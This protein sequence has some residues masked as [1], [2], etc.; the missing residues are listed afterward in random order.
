MANYEQNSYTISTTGSHTLNL[1]GSFTP[2]FF[3][4]S[5]AP[6]TSTN[7]TVVINSDGWQDI[8]NSRKYAK[9]IFDD[10]TVRGTRETTS[11]AITHYKNVSGTL[12][13][14]ISGLV[15]SVGAGTFDVNFD[16]VDSNYTV[17]VKAF[18]A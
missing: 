17:R 6:R 13:K 9:S 11:Y 12:T 8:T 15:T 5:I 14:I 18:G 16:T 10:G 2:A 1:D 4:F 7:E 3:E